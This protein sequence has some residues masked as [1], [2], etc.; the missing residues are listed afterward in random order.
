[1]STAKYIILFLL[2]TLF[3][4]C[5]QEKNDLQGILNHGY[6]TNKFYA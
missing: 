1:M 6:E 5:S 2:G 3:I 4:A